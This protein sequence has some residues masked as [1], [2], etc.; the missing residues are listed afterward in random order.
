VLIA[1]VSAPSTPMLYNRL[2]VLL[3]AP[4]APTMTIRGSPNSSSSMSV[5]MSRF[6]A[7]AFSKAS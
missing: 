5:S 4:P 3:P 2:T 6:S 1:T 7:S